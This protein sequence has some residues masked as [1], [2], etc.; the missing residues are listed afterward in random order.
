MRFSYPFRT[1]FIPAVVC[2]LTILS[3]CGAGIGISEELEQVP[4]LSFMHVHIEQDFNLD[5]LPEELNSVLPMWFC[6]SLLARGPLGLSLLGINLTDLSPQLQFLTAG[7]PEDKVGE[8]AASGFGCELVEKSGYFNLIAPGGSLSGSVA[9][10]NGWT[11]TVIGS[12][13]E[14]AVQRWLELDPEESLAGDSLL[15]SIAEGDG[16]LTV[17]VSENTMTFVMFIPDGMLSRAEKP[18]M[19]AVRSVIDAIDPSALRLAFTFREVTPYAATLELELL[20]RGGELSTMTIEIGDNTISPDSLIT[21]I[22]E[23]LGLGS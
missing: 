4:G 15:L 12:G 2:I 22:T 11:C 16:Q 5:L 7:I 9:G 10:R 8:I 14:S 18:I 21:A 6:D 17:L 23:L 19:Q 1:M 3:G 20:R 13:A